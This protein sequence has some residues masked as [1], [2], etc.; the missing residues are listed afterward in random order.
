MV[1]VFGFL[2]N[3]KRVRLTKGSQK[4]QTH[5]EGGVRS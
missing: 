5:L 2:G 3:A 1:E 4:V